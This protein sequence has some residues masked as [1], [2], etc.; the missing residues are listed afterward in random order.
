MTAGRSSMT[1]VAAVVTVRNERDLLRQNILFHR[2]LGVSR[3][4]VFID[5]STDDTPRTVAD[6]DCVELLPS[7]S[8]GSLLADAH[9]G[10]LEQSA[11]FRLTVE[12]AH[13]HHTARQILNTCAALE[14]A[15]ASGISWLLSFDADELLCPD[16]DTLARDQ[17]AWLLS[18]IDAGVEQV[19]FPPLEMLQRDT[20]YSNVFAEA[21]VF[22]RPDAQNPHPVYDPFKKQLLWYHQ[23]AAAG[24]DGSV[25]YTE[26]FSWWYGHRAGKYAVRVGAGVVP[27]VHH[28]EY[29][30]GG[31]PASV[32]RG[33]LLHYTLYNCGAFINKF[34]NFGRYP[35]RQEHGVPLTYRKRLWR[36]LVNDEEHAGQDIC[37]YYRRWV[38][39]SNAELQRF[40]SA[41]PDALVVV[42]APS[43]FWAPPAANPESQPVLRRGS[44]R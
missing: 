44:Q 17:L 37:S 34:R 26:R 15:R 41:H 30:G 38:A 25:R 33:C 16:T 8:T 7:I 12:S 11:R 9:R 14:R 40:S 5:G 22:K 1:T 35:D 29:Y 39:F 2:Y 18:E 27:L 4:Y 36:D 24:I 10:R 43:Y 3:F 32:A 13:S 21:T 42:R 23:H 28:C 20:T 19:V 6:L 31:Q